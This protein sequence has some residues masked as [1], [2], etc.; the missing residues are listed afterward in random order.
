MLKNA[1]SAI[2][3]KKT[4]STDVNG[5]VLKEPDL[6]HKTFY[7]STENNKKELPISKLDSP[8]SIDKYTIQFMAKENA[9]A[10]VNA[11]VNSEDYKNIGMNNALYSGT[12]VKNALVG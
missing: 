1:E 5:N 3:N 12:S 6:K 7:S 10:L 9:T 11:L 4:Q 8:N 2:T